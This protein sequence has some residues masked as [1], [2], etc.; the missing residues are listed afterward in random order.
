MGPAEM[1]RLA[2]L[3]A[4]RMLFEEQDEAV[5]RDV[6]ALREPFRTLRFCV[7]G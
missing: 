1:T 2:A 7:D 3:M 5:R 4:R 6:L